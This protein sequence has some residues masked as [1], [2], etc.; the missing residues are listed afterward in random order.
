MPNKLDL[1]F[2]VLSSMNIAVLHRIGPRQYTFFGNVPPFYEAAFPGNGASPCCA[3]WE[4]SS[5]LEL[6]FEDAEAFFNRGQPG[7]FSSGIWQEEGIT[8]EGSAMIAL[9]KIFSCGTKAIIIRTL[10][11]DYKERVGILR[12]AREQ[13][14]ENR[15]LSQDLEIFKEKSR[16][17][18]LTKLLNRTTF[19]ELLR[20]E[21]QKSQTGYSRLS[22][23]IMDIDNFKMINDLFGH[24]TGDQVLK[25]LGALLLEHLRQGDIA[26]RY[27]GEEFVV[28]IPGAGPEQ[29]F[30]IGEKLRQFIESSNTA[31][32]PPITVSMGCTTYNIGENAEEFIQRA[33]LALYDAK[34]SGKNVVRMR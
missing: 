24:L 31:G 13:L 20:D 16:F 17:D 9:A 11:E 18:G 21:I 12:K 2:N 3:P 33:D 23:L 4:Y 28:I 26:A 7:V 29:A 27:G 25:N 15:T 1:A 30:K 32:L 14:L 5:M 19:M 8:V 10:Q 6:F 22:L 34:R